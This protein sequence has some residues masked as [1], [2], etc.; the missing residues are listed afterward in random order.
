VL[1]AWRDEDFE[2]FAHLNSDPEVMRW[3]PST[4][5][6]EQ[7][8][9]SAAWIREHLRS[10]GWGLWALEVPGVSSFCGFVGLN[11][12]PFEAS[13]TPAVEIGWR[14]D[15]PWWGAGYA[16][17]AARACLIFGFATLGLAQIV[18]F[19]TTQNVRSRGVMERLG[20]THDPVHDFDHPNIPDGHPL[21]RHVFYRLAAP[22]ID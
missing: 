19:T 4:Y 2:P 14:L 3:F 1:R 17:E 20:M 8:N 6:A 21:K 9:A 16:T 7:S 13:F 15:R 10:E 5:S 11:T 22:G 18:S 12:V